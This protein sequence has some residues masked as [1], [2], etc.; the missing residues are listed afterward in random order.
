MV[1]ILTGV[2][3][4][5]ASLVPANG[6]LYLG[7]QA[8]A[9]TGASTNLVI[10]LGNVSNISSVNL[11]ISTDL[12]A[13]YGSSWYSRTDLYYGVIGDITPALNGDP[14]YTLYASVTSG[15]TPWT[16]ASS[17]SQHGTANQINGM[18]AQLITDNGNAQ[19]G[20]AANSI[21]MATSEGGSWT[22]YNTYG[23]GAFGGF[24]GGIETTT[25]SALDIYRLIPNA[26]GPNGTIAATLNLASNGTFSV[27]AVPEP[28]AYA[29]F[30]LGALLMAFVLRRKKCTV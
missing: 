23:T 4:A 27:V 22:A 5:K 29:L 18:V 7:F 6:D 26:A 3:S 25:G 10:D 14:N 2:L 15:G 17:S 28:S 13:I 19:F 12:S 11:N 20:T 21:L 16:S 24:P 9:G 1:L 30:G 8:A